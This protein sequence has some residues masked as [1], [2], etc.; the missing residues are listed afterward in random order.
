MK[1]RWS[2]ITKG[3]LFVCATPIGNLKDI[4]KRLIETLQSVDLI[5][6]EDTRKFQILA[7]EFQIQKP[8]ISLEKFNES[9]RIKT[10]QT[11]LDKGKNIALI[12]EAGTPGI[13]DPGAYLINNLT[14]N[15]TITPI[16]GPCAITTLLSVSGLLADQYLFAGF[17]P[18]SESLAKKELLKFNPLNTPII[19]FESPKRM[20]KTCEFLKKNL[21][22]TPLIIG[23]ELTKKFETIIYTTTTNSIEKLTN[24]PIK[25]EWVFIIKPDKK[26]ENEVNE[27]IN[28]L[29]KLSLTNKDISTICKIFG[30]PKNKVYDQL[31]H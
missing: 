21:P 24:I 10:L 3:T 16:P 5:A 22:D 14:N 13:A 2:S 8:C 20:L 1:G 18:K 9:S 12:S 17:F 23:K 15:H 6:C 7:N 11:K 25:G 28:K 27:K 30:L 26:N 31:I 4:S 29:K 19:Y